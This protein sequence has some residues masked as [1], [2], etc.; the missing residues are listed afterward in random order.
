MHTP[1]PKGVQFDAADGRYRAVLQ[2]G[3]RQVYLA[4]FATAE[5]A[6][7]EWARAKKIMDEHKASGEPLPMW[8]LLQKPQ[9]RNSRLRAIPDLLARD[10]D[11]DVL[12][13]RRRNRESKR[14]AR[15]RAWATAHP[16]AAQSIITQLSQQEAGCPLPA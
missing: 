5:A 4:R 14:A 7:A 12:A 16:Q 6:A 3:R 10:L 11:E 15:W 2:V 1:R 13:E 9:K 8:K